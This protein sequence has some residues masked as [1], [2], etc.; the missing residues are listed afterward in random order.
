MHTGTFRVRA[1]LLVRACVRE[2]RTRHTHK[3]G[4]KTGCVNTTH[5]SDYLTA[6]V[7]TG[8]LLKAP[9]LPVNLSSSLMDT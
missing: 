5:D 6:D 7:T 8:H 4:V 3:E 9:L 1:D 2:R